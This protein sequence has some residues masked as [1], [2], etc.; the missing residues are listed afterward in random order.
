MWKKCNFLEV[1][2][3]MPFWISET[4]YEMVDHIY[5]DIYWEKYIC[6]MKRVAE[7]K[8]D[9]DECIFMRKD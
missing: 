4:E 7:S 2:E 6:H 8:C 3:K 1:R 9:K 5:K